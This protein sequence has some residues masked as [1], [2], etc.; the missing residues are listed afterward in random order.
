MPRTAFQL[1]KPRNRTF[2]LGSTFRWR[3]VRFEA[4]RL[5]FRLLIAF[6]F[7]KEQ[8]RATLA[9]A[10]ERDLSVLASYEF[11]GTHPG[12]HVLA[13]CGDVEGVPAGMMKGPWQTR[14]PKGRQ[15]HRRVRFSIANE[16]AALTV[17]ADF[18]QLNKAEGGLL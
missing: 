18:F 7:E 13:A 16:D 2:R 6:S 4:V 17:A 5:K 15:F 11:H 10:R 8:Y 14:F 1:S 9:L 3:V 12:W